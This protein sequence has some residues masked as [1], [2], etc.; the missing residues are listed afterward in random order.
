M[1]RNLSDFNVFR[2]ESASISFPNVE[3]IDAFQ[4]ASFKSTHETINTK[5][6]DSLKIFS[7]LARARPITDPHRYP[8]AAVNSTVECQ[9]ARCGLWI[10]ESE[11]EERRK[12]KSFENAK[13]NRGSTDWTEDVLTR[14]VEKGF[15]KYIWSLKEHRRCSI[16]F[17]RRH[18]NLFEGSL[19][20]KSFSSDI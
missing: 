14:V 19:W 3:R 16:R 1:I 20:L 9:T 15:S 18:F 8:P 13:L 2:R 17:H 12:K 6:K 5:S 4:F 7:L 10:A 11:P